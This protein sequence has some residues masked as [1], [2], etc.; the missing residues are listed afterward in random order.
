MHNYLY[1]C[2]QK[3]TQMEAKRMTNSFA[4]TLLDPADTGQA[5][6]GLLATVHASLAYGR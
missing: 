3:M 4:R 5:G 6:L 1:F 2:S